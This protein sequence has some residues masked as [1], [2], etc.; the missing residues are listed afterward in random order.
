ME[1]RGWGGLKAQFSMHLCV[2]I[3]VLIHSGKLGHFGA[4]DEQSFGGP[5]ICQSNVP[6][7][8]GWDTPYKEET[9]VTILPFF[10]PTQPV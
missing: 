7:I 9:K 1:E 6:Y 8:A 5:C 10:H 3:I 4:P 2:G